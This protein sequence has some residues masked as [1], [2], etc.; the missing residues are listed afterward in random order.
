MSENHGKSPLPSLRTIADTLKIVVSDLIITGKAV[1]DP[2][3]EQIYLNLTNI[4]F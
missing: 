4:F 2:H 1:R 3:L